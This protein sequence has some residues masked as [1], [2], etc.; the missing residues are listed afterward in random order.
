MRNS[1]TLSGNTDI[2]N[3][4]ITVM[5]SPFIQNV[6]ACT[7]FNL[8]NWL[9]KLEGALNEK[10]D[11]RLNERLGGRLTL[12]LLA[13]RGGENGLVQWETL[14]LDLYQWLKVK[15]SSS[16]LV[17]VGTDPAQAND[18]VGTLR[19][20]IICTL[21][22][23]AATEYEVGGLLWEDARD[24]FGSG[25]DGAWFY[26]NLETARLRVELGTYPN[27]FGAYMSD[28]LSLS[29]S[30][31]HQIAVKYNFA[32]EVQA[33]VSDE[34]W[35]KLFNDE[36]K[37]AVTAA[38]ARLEQ[39]EREK[40]AADHIKYAIEIPADGRPK[41]ELKRVEI[42]LEQRFGSTHATV[43][44]S[45]DSYLVVCECRYTSVTNNRDYRRRLNPAEAAWVENRVAGTIADP[46]RDTWHSAPGGDTM[47]V[48]IHRTN[49]SA[50]SQ[51]FSNPSRK[52][53]DLLN[54]LEKLAHYGSK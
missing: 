3:K 6:M 40:A 19:E 12:H 7:F 37:A 30:G 53:T 47:T 16:S 25:W 8:L 5:L 23:R 15:E 39:R 31:F 10:L 21:T 38:K 42:M 35:K 13:P 11:G 43:T 24:C 26:L 34:D 32:P 2:Q 33:F 46:N 51:S 50:I 41:M 44:P 54:D 9:E 27:A 14:I 18:P 36:L 28:S 29:A 4:T 48:T 1:E 20:K 45:E 22:I 49:A 52:Y 17:A